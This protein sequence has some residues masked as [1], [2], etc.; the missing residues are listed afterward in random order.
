[1]ALVIRQF[2]PDDAEDWFNVHR[3]AVHRI[4]NAD[5]PQAVVD[6]WAPPLTPR[7]IETLRLAPVDGK[8]VA[9]VGEEMAGIGELS[10]ESAEVRAVYVSPDFARR[11]IG[12]ALATELEKLAT[13]AGIATLSV[14]S[15]ITAEPFYRRLGYHVTARGS[16]VLHT[17][18]PMAS[19]F[20]KKALTA[21]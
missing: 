2:V 3:A 15:S 20:M 21:A 13:G 16:H 11:G 18:E 12:R 8:I 4:A 17:G 19:V 7:M 5:Y 9:I 10:A 6:A 1:M 14:H